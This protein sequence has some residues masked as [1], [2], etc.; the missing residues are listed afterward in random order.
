MLRDHGG[1][2]QCCGA[3]PTF[4]NP[5][6]VDHIKPRRYFPELE[7]NINNLQVLCHDCNVGKG[8]WDTTDWRKSVRF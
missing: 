6:H 4:D 5:L 3:R 1:R 7:L 2:C 8:A